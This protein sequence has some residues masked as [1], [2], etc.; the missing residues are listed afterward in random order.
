MALCATQH[1][2]GVI[3]IVQKDLKQ[4]S[5]TQYILIDLVIQSTQY[6]MSSPKTRGRVL[7]SHNAGPVKYHSYSAASL[8]SVCNLQFA[9]ASIPARNRSLINLTTN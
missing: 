2:S 8:K 6:M 3:G 1:I 9:V 4:L 7:T 5:N